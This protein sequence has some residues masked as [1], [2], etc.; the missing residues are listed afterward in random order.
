MF[1]AYLFQQLIFNYTINYNQDSNPDGR[2]TS[3]LGALAG[4]GTVKHICPA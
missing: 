2:R 3:R 4:N 1:S